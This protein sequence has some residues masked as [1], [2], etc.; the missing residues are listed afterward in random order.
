MNKKITSTLLAALMIAGATT[1]TTFAAMQKGTVVIG[2]KAYDIDYANNPANIKEITKEIVDGGAIYIKNFNGDWISNVTALKVASSVIPAVVYKDATGVTNYGAA[3]TSDTT[4]PGGG[5][6]P[7][8]ITAPVLNAASFT[9]GNQVSAIK[10]AN[11][12]YKI[13]LFG[14]SDTTM[15]TA[16][17]LNA[18]E[19]STAEINFLGFPRT[20]T[21]NADGYVNVTITELL[22]ALDPQGDGVSVK[23]LKSYLDNGT[24]TLTAKLTDASGNTKTFTITITTN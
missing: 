1:F 24:G 8:D 11:G 9:I 2:T 15:F 6:T 19:K 12:N 21:T 23:T 3:D 14:L 20:V 16:I 5:T 7:V 17:T 18:S 10:D 22:G 4:T 13:S